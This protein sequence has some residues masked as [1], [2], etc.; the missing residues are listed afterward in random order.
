[1][2]ATMTNVYGRRSA[3]RTIH[4]AALQTAAAGSRLHDRGGVTRHARWPSQAADTGRHAGEATMKHGVAVVMFALGLPLPPRK[5]VLRPRDGVPHYVYADPAVCHCVYAGT[6]QQ[7]Q[8]FK[9]LGR[10]AQIARE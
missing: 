10:E 2:S 8:D 7:Y 1:S 9:K 4:I 3:S 5:V 6:E